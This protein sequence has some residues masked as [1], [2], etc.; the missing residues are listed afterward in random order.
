[1]SRG[2]MSDRAVHISFLPHG[3]VVFE[4]ILQQNIF[5]Y[6]SSEPTVKSSS[7][8]SH[9][10]EEPG[11]L[12]LLIPIEYNENLLRNH[13]PPPPPS[14]SSPTTTTTGTT[15]TVTH[16]ELWG[17][18]MPDGLA[19]TLRIGDLLKID[20]IFYCPEKLIFARNIRIEKYRSLGRLQG[21]ICEIKDGR[22]Y[23]FIK[24]LY[25]GP[26]TYFKTS[27]VIKGSSFSVEV[28]SPVTS[29][30]VVGKGD[31]NQ[32]MDERNVKI[33]LPVSYEC[34]IEEVSKL[35]H[36]LLPTPPSSPPPLLTSLLL[37]P[38]L[39]SISLLGWWR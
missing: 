17:R 37:H 30:T 19:S 25:G 18:C 3:T 36:S 15:K 21:S 16:V 26:D 31:Q 9:R 32:L 5:A 2:K 8:N 11:M 27:E 24:C 7:S 29:S 6:V 4:K 22:G 33:S 12:R 23:G 35:D 39:I 28:P 10:Q 14:S 38:F 34:S 1:M 20:A 13:L